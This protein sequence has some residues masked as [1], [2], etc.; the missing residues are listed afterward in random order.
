MAATAIRLRMLCACGGLTLLH[1]SA[2]MAAE[3]T[4]SPGARVLTDYSS[5]PR[6]LV[7]GGEESTSAVGELSAMLRRR[8]E[9]SEWWLQPRLYSEWHDNDDVLNRDDEYLRAGVT[10]YWERT[11]WN[12]TLNFA[13]D[14]TVTSELGLTGITEDNRKHEGFSV[15]AGPSFMLSERT[16]A[17]AQLS[18][19]H[20]HYRNAAFT[21]LV[22]YQYGALS[23]FVGHTLSDRTEWSVS[24]HAGELRVPVNPQ[25]DKQD[26]SL[27]LGWIYKPWPLWTWSLSAGPSTARSDERSDDG[28]V[29]QTDL[30][31]RGELWTFTTTAGRDITPTGRGELTR[32]DQLSVAVSRA[33]TERLSASAAVRGVRNQDLLTQTGRGEELEY[34][35]VELRINW[36]VAQEWSVAL[37]FAGATQ[38]LESRRDGADNYGASLSIVWNGQSQFL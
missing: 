38:K 8:S 10:H 30:Q 34:G 22:D 25:A 31:H 28:L 36:R 12:A 17:G 15:S 21:G 35:R 1:A 9:R 18:W 23:G 3:W 20:N 6:L 37:G 19:N 24:L 11:Q 13:H 32:R 7:E 2:G 5:N 14:T 27:T 33:L 4:F 16:N 29:F 26:A